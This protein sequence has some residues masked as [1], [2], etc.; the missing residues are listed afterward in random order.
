MITWKACHTCFN[1]II[2]VNCG[3]EEDIYNEQVTNEYFK[4]GIKL[5]KTNYEL[6]PNTNPAKNV[7]FFLGKFPELII[8]MICYIELFSF[9]LRYL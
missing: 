6:Q 1:V 2:D 7:V 5:I 8:I 3:P 4:E 9:R